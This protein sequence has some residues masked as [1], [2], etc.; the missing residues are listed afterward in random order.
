MHQHP[1]RIY[2][3]AVY[4][5]NGQD[6]VIE[7]IFHLLNL[8]IQNNTFFEIGTQ[9]G[10]ECNTRYFREN[11]NWYGIMIDGGYQNPN[12]NL[13]QHLVTAENVCDIL[14]G[15]QCPNYVNFL[16]LDIDFNTFYVLGALIN[17]FSFDIIDVEYNSSYKDDW[18]VQYDPNGQWDGSNYFGASL[19]SF[20]LLLKNKGYSLIYTDANGADAF[21]VKDSLAKNLNL[22]DINNPDKIYSPP[23]YGDGKGHPNDIFNRKGVTLQEAKKVFE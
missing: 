10:S 20:Y 1:L 18:I 12:I 11:H 14:N 23:R 2:E 13:F 22:P 21:F 8:P 4:S 6:G 5:Q 17:Q 19:L 16:S 15:Y 3:K 9:D 7:Q